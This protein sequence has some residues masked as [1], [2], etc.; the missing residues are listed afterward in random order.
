[1]C[2]AIL[3]TAAEV[4][5]IILQSQAVAVVQQAVLDGTIKFNHLALGMVSAFLQ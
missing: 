3:F 4:A 5:R 1:M 2:W